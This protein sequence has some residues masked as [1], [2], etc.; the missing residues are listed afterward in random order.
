MNRTLLIILILVGLVAFGGVL[1][2]SAY[3]QLVAVDEG[4]EQSWG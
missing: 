2:I 1:G 4:V 3:N